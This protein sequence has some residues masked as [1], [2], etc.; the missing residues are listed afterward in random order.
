MSN[1][2][3]SDQVMGIFGILFSLIILLFGVWMV[4]L[5]IEGQETF[6]E[7]ADESCGTFGCTAEEEK[8]IDEFMES[9]QSKVII[10]QTLWGFAVMSSVYLMYTSFRL[11]SGTNLCR[12]LL[13][14]EG[15]SMYVGDR[16]FFLY[17][18]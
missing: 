14:P 11:A 3:T 17:T 8:E 15:H 4:S 9:V 2:K 5:L 13:I 10:W 18:L 16:S 12:G 6:N 7:L 1:I